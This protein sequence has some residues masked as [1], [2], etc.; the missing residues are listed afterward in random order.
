MDRQ[1]LLV[2]VAGALTGVFSGLTGVGGGVILVSMMVSF[3]GFTQHRAHGTS[4]A[5]IIFLALF[6]AIATQ[7]DG[8][9]LTK[10]FGAAMLCFAYLFTFKHA[11]QRVAQAARPSP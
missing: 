5:V 8:F 2:L 7:I 1:R 11:R 10:I 6:G 9:W 3:L 4:L